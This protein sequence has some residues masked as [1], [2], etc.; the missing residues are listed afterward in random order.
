VRKENRHA[1]KV[2]KQTAT[3]G[4][5]GATRASRSPPAKVRRAKFEKQ[6]K[7]VDTRG[8]SKKKKLTGVYL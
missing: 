2:G 7:K 8:E 4:A 5:I 1:E 6:P 3:T